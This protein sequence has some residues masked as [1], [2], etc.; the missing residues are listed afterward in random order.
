[1]ILLC[2]FSSLDQKQTEKITAKNQI[3][4]AKDQIPTAKKQIPA[5]EEQILS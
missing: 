1:M 5:K 4:T 3:P 2:I